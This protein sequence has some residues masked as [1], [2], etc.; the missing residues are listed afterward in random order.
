MENSMKTHKKVDLPSTGHARGYHGA[1]WCQAALLSL[2]PRRLRGLKKACPVES[3]KTARCFAVLQ[4]RALLLQR[5]AGKLGS[6][7]PML[8]SCG[9]QPGSLIA[10]V[11]DPHGKDDSGPDIGQG[12]YSHRVA[13]TL[14]PLALIVVQSPGFL[15]CRLPGELMQGVAQR[16]DTG[17][18]AVGLEVGATLK[19]DRRGACQRL[20]TGRIGIALAVIPDFCQQTRGQ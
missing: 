13:F 14:R 11:I 15:P 4:A 2:T 16:L 1:A 18:A 12:P 19:Q 9:L 20:Q 3:E 17:I 8:L 7:V 5:V 10:G 6:L